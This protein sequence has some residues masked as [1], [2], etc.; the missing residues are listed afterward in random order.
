MNTANLCLE[1]LNLTTAV[2]RFMGYSVDGA[3]PLATL[4]DRFDM[5]LHCDEGNHDDAPTLM[6]EYV[7]GG[8]LTAGN[9][10]VWME[11]GRP[12]V[13]A[14]VPFDRTLYIGWPQCFVH[15]LVRPVGAGRRHLVAAWEGDEHAVM[16]QFRDNVLLPSIKAGSPFQ[17]C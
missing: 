11:E 10:T 7:D 15:T 14:V 17:L 4:D 2:N 13:R 12:Q 16:S 1:S 8:R 3:G 5:L 9:L 6:A